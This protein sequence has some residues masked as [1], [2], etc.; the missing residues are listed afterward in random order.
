MDPRDWLMNFDDGME[1][2]LDHLCDTHGVFAL[3][4]GN[5]PES[6]KEYK[7]RHLDRVVSRMGEFLTDDPESMG[8]DAV[9]DD[10]IRFFDMVRGMYGLDAK[11]NVF[12]YVIDLRYLEARHGHR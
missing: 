4:F 12:N 6:R 3:M 8:R 5:N 2:E 11:T 10:M 9:S 1:S 7:D